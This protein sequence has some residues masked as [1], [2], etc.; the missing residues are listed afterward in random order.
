M[1]SRELNRRSLGKTI[2]AM[3]MLA[4]VQPL[5]PLV[6]AEETQAG[7]RTKSRDAA[8]SQELPFVCISRRTAE[9]D[10]VTFLKRREAM[11]QGE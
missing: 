10:L 11:N 2:V 9:G 6:A 3:A 1:S 7:K 4:T 5:R 8:S